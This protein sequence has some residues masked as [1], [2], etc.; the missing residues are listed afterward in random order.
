MTPPATIPMVDLSAWSGGSAMARKRIASE[1]TEACRRVGFVYVVNHRIP[2]DLLDEA[3]AWSRRLFDLPL[4][5]KMLAPHPPGT[6]TSINTPH[7]TCSLSS[8]GLGA[9]RMLVTDF[10]NM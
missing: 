3:F 8:R 5:K 6:V 9:L 10:G 1:L 7:C 4:E 2:A